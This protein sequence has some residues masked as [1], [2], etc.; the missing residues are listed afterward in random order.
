MKPLPRA[1]RGGARARRPHRAG[2]RAAGL[3]AR[4]EPDGMSEPSR[5][6]EEADLDRVR[7]L[8]SIG[9]GHAAN[10]LRA[11]R[12]AAPARCACRRCA[13]E[14]GARPSRRRDDERVGAAC[15]S[16][17]RAGSAACSRCSSRARPAS[18]SSRSCSARASAGCAR[19][20]GP[21][22][23]RASSAT[24]SPRTP[25]TR[26]AR[27]LGVTR[28]ALDSAAR[29]RRRA[30]ALAALLARRERGRAGAPHR[31]RDL[32]PRTRAA[33]PP[34]VRARHELARGA[35]RARV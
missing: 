21:V 24:S 14:A 4:P 18:A 19:R 15:S 25:S 32:R 1:P 5:S 26:S 11:A 3:R 6:V 31:D 2:R 28:A 20:R 27:S 13:C 33:R 29:A 12:S 8:A 34:R 10:A 16:R 30:R 17:S 22:G 7:E 9:A 23:A 35:P